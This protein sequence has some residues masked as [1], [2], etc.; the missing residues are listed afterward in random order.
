MSNRAPVPVVTLSLIGLNLAAAVATTLDPTLA[1]RYGFWAVRPDGFRAFT[2]LFLHANLLHLAGNLIFLAAVGP[3]VEFHARAWRLGTV[4]I[5]SGLAGVGAHYVVARSLEFSPPLVGASGAIAGVV[6]Y[7]TLLYMGMKVPVAPKLGLRVSVLTL[8][9]VAMQGVGALMANNAEAGS[10]AYWSHL[11]GFFVGL[12][13]AFM[14]RAPKQASLRIGHEALDRMNQRSPAAVLATAEAIL[15]KHPSDPR[16]L[17]DRAIAYGDLHEPDKEAAAIREWVERTQGEPQRESL[18]YIRDHRL[19]QALEP[20]DRARLAHAYQEDS[21]G[22]ALL[23]SLVKGPDNPQRAD[24]LLSLAECLRD[25]DPVRSQALLTELAEKYS[26]HGAF[27]LAQQ[28]GHWPLPKS[29]A[30][31]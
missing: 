5:A 4:Y 29:G 3:L 10:T 9:W 31:S 21:L 30:K 26:G 23:E 13:L 16:A 18:A 8:I 22:E 7:A 15:A 17:R 19:W 20:L 6:A 11:A 25:R 2:S 12:A 27:Q 24:A 1:D 28:R 14:F